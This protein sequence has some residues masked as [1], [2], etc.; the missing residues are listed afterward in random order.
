MCGLINV[1][2]TRVLYCILNFIDRIIASRVTFLFLFLQF[3]IKIKKVDASRPTTEQN[4]LLHVAAIHI[5]WFFLSSQRLPVTYLR[6]TK[7]I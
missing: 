3:S 4:A 6:L 7:E 5:E 1:G 2:F